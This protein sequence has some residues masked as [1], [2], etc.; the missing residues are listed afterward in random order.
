MP[1]HSYDFLVIGAGPAGSGA[2]SAAA[3]AGRSVALI[4]RD[5]IGGTCL[6]YGCDPTKAL[7]HLAAQLHEAGRAARTGLH[8]GDPTADWEKVQAYLRKTINQVR[9][10]SDAATRRKLG[11]EGIDVYKGTARFLSPHEVRVNGETLRAE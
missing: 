10:G 11:G 3:Q 4:E 1:S 8:L 9:G 5:K 2:A 7:L 6:N